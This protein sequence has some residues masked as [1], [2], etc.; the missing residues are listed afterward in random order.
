MKQ[1]GWLT[2]ETPKPRPA[3]DPPPGNGTHTHDSKPIGL[4]S[5]KVDR[6]QHARCVGHV[7][8]EGL[9]R[10]V[11]VLAGQSA[12]DVVAEALELAGR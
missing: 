3:G 11:C 12:A 7:E 1:H 5:L 6:L 10:P 4:S 8:V 9:T 2:A